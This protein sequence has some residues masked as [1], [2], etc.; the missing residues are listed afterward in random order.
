MEGEKGSQINLAQLQCFSI[1]FFLQEKMRTVD[2]HLKGG[3]KDATRVG[4]V[5]E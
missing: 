1:F 2:F 4:D 5:R 3:K